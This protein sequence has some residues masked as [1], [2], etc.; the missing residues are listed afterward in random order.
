MSESEPKRVCVLSPKEVR[1]WEQ[2]GEEPQCRNHWHAKPEHAREYLIPWCSL[3]NLQTADYAPA[4]RLVDKD[5]PWIT[6]IRAS[7]WRVVGQTA[8]AR[9]E[10]LPGVPG[11]P[12]WQMVLGGPL[13]TKNG[14]RK[15]KWP[16][17]RR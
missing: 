3:K 7:D 8:V 16:R 1:A 12:H 13:L 4:V 6:F 11:F 5:K 17:K 15:K 9:G 14:R 2:Y 10:H